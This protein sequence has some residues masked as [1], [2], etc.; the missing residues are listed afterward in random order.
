MVAVGKRGPIHAIF[1]RQEVE[2]IMNSKFRIL[3]YFVRIFGLYVQNTQ[4]EEVQ[5]YGALRKR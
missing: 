1:L 3:N 5:L 4:N 2:C